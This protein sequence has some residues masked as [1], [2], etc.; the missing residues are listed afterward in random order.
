MPKL[1]NLPRT[2]STRTPPTPSPRPLNMSETHQ[3]TGRHQDMYTNCHPDGHQSLKKPTTK[4]ANKTCNHTAI[5]T[6]EIIIESN[7]T[8]NTQEGNNTDT[9]GVTKRTTKPHTQENTA[10]PSAK[11]TETPRVQWTESPSARWK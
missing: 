8:E 5:H 11:W 2:L 4:R 10:P 9:K 7:E 1:C 3:N 6:T